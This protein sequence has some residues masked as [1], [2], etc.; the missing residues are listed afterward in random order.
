MAN[1]NIVHALWLDKADEKLH[2][3]SLSLVSNAFFLP[4]LHEG[5]AKESFR[6]AK[7]MSELIRWT[8]RM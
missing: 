2:V 7:E 5:R 1:V 4:A 3:D 6:M 8:K